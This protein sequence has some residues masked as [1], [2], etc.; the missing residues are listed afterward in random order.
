MEFRITLKDGT[1]V[2]FNTMVEVQEWMEEHSV[3]FDWCDNQFGYWSWD[4]G[5]MTR[6]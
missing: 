1:V 4:G 5:E 3:E 2:E 6:A